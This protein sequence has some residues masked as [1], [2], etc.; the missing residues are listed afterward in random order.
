M[1]L[2]RNGRR[3][4]TTE[5]VHVAQTVAPMLPPRAVNAVEWSLSRAGPTLPVLS[6]MVAE[7]MRAAG[8][9]NL[10]DFREYFVHVARH[11][12][13][14]LRILRIGGQA[15]AVRQFAR[16]ETDVH[17]SVL[18]IRGMMDQGKG[19]VIA[20]AHVCNYLLTLVR[21]NEEVPVCVY[22]RWSKDKRKREMKRSWCQ[23]AGLRVILEPARRADPAS[24]ARAC[25]K[26][27]RSGS[28]LVMT[29]D[30]AV[31]ADQGVPIRLLGRQA[32]LPAGPATI[33]MLAGAPLIALFARPAGRKQELYACKPIHIEPA[34]RRKWGR[35]ASI[36]RAMQ[37]WADYFEAFLRDAPQTWFFWGDK[38]WTRVFH[39][40]SRFVHPLSS[41]QDYAESDAAHRKEIV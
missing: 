11:L 40:D 41:R 20:P 25:T 19:V 7:N 13:N 33:A 15:C 14:A 26:L 22:L 28:A 36:Q 29:P 32:Y 3:W 38:R 39:G 5:A 6:R 9:Y 23:A 12:T 27:V 18:E 2:L 30:I 37:T 34:E 10:R 24:R 21:L 35:R 31:K 4:L 8:L 17:E 1:T 16:S